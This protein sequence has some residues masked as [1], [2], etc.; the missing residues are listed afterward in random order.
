MGFPAE[1]A[2]GT[3][4]EIE[5]K[6]F[7]EARQEV[8][9]ATDGTLYTRNNAVGGLVPYEALGTAEDAS[10]STTPDEEADALAGEP[11]SSDEEPAQGTS[12]PPS[13]QGDGDAPNPSTPAEAA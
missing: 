5:S 10:E 1:L 4:V 6:S 13:T 8:F 11:K 7:D 2:D 3:V 9:T 12:A